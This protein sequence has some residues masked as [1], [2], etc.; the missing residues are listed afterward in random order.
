MLLVT[1]ILQKE[2]KSMSSGFKLVKI[3]FLIIPYKNQSFI[4]NNYVYFRCI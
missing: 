2:V 1:D 4:L 3:G